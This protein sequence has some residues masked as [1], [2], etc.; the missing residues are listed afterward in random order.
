MYEVLEEIVEVK[1]ITTCYVLIF[2]RLLRAATTEG[3]GFSAAS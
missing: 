2:P 3:D 1:W